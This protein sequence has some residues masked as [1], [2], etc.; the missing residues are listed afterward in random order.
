MSKSFESIDKSN[1]QKFVDL[2]AQRF[3]RLDFDEEVLERVLINFTEFM[4]KRDTDKEIEDN[5]YTSP[6]QFRLEN[7]IKFKEFSIPI[8]RS[9]WAIPKAVIKMRTSLYEYEVGHSTILP[10]PS[11]VQQPITINTAPPEKS[12]K[13][14]ILTPL[15]RIIRDPN[16]PHTQMQ[17]FINDIQ[18]L[19]SKWQNILYWYELG[20]RKRDQINSYG[21]LL[22]IVDDIS[23]VFNSYIEST[24]VMVIHLANEFTKTETEEIAGEVLTAYIKAQQQNANK[25]SGLPQIS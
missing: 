15:K 3:Q 12:I 11:T 5:Q 24:L 2:F 23:I 17:E 16:S 8:S 7:H 19:P 14:K 6:P 21:R 10:E 13:E 25:F 22:K 9:M 1:V 18:I 20:I 4:A